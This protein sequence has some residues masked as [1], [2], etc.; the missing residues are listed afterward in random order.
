MCALNLFDTSFTWIVIQSKTQRYLISSDVSTINGDLDLSNVSKWFPTI[1]FTPKCCTR[2]HIPN[3]TA[4]LS[5][6]L[7][8]PLQNSN[9]MRIFCIPTQPRGHDVLVKTTI[10]SSSQN[11]LSISTENDANCWFK[12]IL[13]IRSTN[14]WQI[15]SRPWS[16]KCS[17]LWSNTTTT[18]T[19]A[20]RCRL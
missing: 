12:T 17:E 15:I 3:A 16:L 1:A 10:A 5:Q 19:V 4:Y 6:W 14:R 9:V 2:S 7:K 20:S 8:H 13:L 18:W 11:S